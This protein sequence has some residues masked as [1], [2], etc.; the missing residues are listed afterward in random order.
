MLNTSTK[1]LLFVLFIGFLSLGQTKA[2]FLAEFAIVS[3][4]HQAS[5]KP[6]FSNT[7]RE[8]EKFY[9]VSIAYQS[10]LMDDSWAG[11]FSP[12]WDKGIEENLQLLLR[13]SDFKFQ[14]GK[15]DFYFLQKKGQSEKAISSDK[16]FLPKPMA[17]VAVIQEIEGIVMDEEGIPIPGASILI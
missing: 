10:D 15:G 14:Q 13:D 4:S 3:D 2:Q 11:D 17:Y 12:Q 8:L 16:A 9:K 5:V 1:T 7:L 6:N